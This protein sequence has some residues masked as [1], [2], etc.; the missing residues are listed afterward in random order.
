MKKDL[1]LKKFSEEKISVYKIKLYVFSI[2]TKK[3]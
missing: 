2:Y 1:I 3:I